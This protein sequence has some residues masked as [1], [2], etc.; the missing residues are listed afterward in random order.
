M[1]PTQCMAPWWKARQAWPCGWMRLAALAS[2]MVRCIAAE[3]APEQ[4]LAALAV[5]AFEQVVP[6]QAVRLHLPNFAE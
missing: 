5:R 6:Q 3:L 1:A 4:V 2:G